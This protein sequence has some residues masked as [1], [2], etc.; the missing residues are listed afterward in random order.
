MEW[1]N[2]GETFIPNSP[3]ISPFLLSYS[4]HFI[5]SLFRSILFNPFIFNHL[6]EIP[7]TIPIFVANI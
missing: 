3:K 6:T 4:L 1:G 2:N 7:R 5:H